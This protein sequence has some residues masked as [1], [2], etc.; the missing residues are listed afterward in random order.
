MEVDGVGENVLG[1]LNAL[2]YL[3]NTMHFSILRGKLFTSANVDNTITH[4]I[5]TTSPS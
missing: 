5:N 4:F 1:Q 3:D 2:Y